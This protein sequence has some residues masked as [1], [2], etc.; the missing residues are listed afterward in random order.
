MQLGL[1]LLNLPKRL[2]G[3]GCW[4]LWRS[5]CAQL[6]IRAV[7]ASAAVGRGCE[8]EV[9]VEHLADHL[10]EQL[11]EALLVAGHIVDGVSAELQDGVVVVG[12]GMLYEEQGWGYWRCRVL[13]AHY[14]AIEEGLQIVVAVVGQALLLENG[15]YIGQW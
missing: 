14:A 8:G 3:T 5:Y 2:R 9:G 7:G 4:A 10:A 15:V 13:R 12:S 1:W 6:P 11:G